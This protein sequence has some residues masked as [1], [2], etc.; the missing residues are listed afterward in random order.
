MNIR[1]CT[2]SLISTRIS[3]TSENNKQQKTANIFWGYKE[4]FLTT[5][6][7]NKV[8]ETKNCAE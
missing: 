1:K 4:K 3:N 6:K 8:A 2:P 7:S 5:F